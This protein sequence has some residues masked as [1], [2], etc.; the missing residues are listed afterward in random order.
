MAKLSERNE[1]RPPVYAEE[2]QNIRFTIATGETQMSKL[3][4]V[5]VTLVDNNQNLKP[6]QRIVYQAINFV[7][8]HNDERTIRQILMTGEVTKALDK[9]NA[10]RTQI[11][12]KD[13][14]RNTGRDVFLEEVEEFDCDWQIVQVA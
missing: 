7:T 10:K 8:E 1:A 12:D 11:V 3:R 4:T 14:L 9:H 2:H 6:K 13:I 5:T